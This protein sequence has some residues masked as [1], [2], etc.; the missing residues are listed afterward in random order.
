[1]RG[2]KLMGKANPLKLV[3]VCYPV[4]IQQL[5]KQRNFS[6]DYPLVDCGIACL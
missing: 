4:V 5:E 6:P 3:V 2:C 1:M